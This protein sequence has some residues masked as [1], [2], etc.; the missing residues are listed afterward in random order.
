MTA[1]IISFQQARKLVSDASWL[2]VQ[3]GMEAY[4]KD[5]KFIVYKAGHG[6]Y[7]RRPSQSW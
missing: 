6:I 3:A 5:M 2:Q 1:E 4:S 7:K